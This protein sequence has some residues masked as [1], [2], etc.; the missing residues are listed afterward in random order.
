MKYLGK[1][2][3]SSFVYGLMIMSWYLVLIGGIIGGIIISIAM[4][5]DPVN[6]PGTSAES[7]LKFELFNE[8]KKDPEAWKF[9]TSTSI[10][11]KILAL[12]I[13]SGLGILLL[14]IINKARLIFKNFKNNVVFHED[15]VK[16]ISII[17]KLLIAFSIVTM[18]FSSLVLSLILLILADV[19]KNGAE[20]QQEHDLTV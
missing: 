17:S 2:S 12:G 1:K 20:L 3:L 18:N 15:N 7:H 13:L 11:F 19:F 10:M 5:S 4:F 16:I 8:I 6:A 9:F 14:V